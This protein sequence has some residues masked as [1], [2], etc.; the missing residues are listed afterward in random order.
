M[1]W[2]QIQGNWREYEGLARERWGKL[3]DDDWQTLAGKK[4]QLV[5]KIQQRYGIAKEEASRQ[6]DEWHSS[7]PATANRA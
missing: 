7:L 4:D 5:G 2:D 6:I 3:T 1:N